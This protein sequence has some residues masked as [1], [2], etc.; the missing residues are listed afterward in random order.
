MAAFP[1][2]EIQRVPL[3]S[4][5]LTV[6]ATREGQDVKAFLQRAIDPPA[7]A[8]M[9]EAL[10]VLRELG[11]LDDRGKLTALG[12]HMVCQILSKSHTM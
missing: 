1:K 7:V 9:D 3:E 10:A 8:A 2:P 5:A 6:K 4:I 11:A 12:R